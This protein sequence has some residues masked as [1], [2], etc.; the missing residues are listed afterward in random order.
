[1]FVDILIDYLSLVPSTP[2]AISIATMVE[3]AGKSLPWETADT[4]RVP[5]PATLLDFSETLAG[6]LRTP[7]K[8]A[9][10]TL[11]WEWLLIEDAVNRA[12][13]ILHQEQRGYLAAPALEAI[14]ANPWY[15]TTIV[16]LEVAAAYACSVPRDVKASQSL[17]IAAQRAIP[18][19]SARVVNWYRSMQDRAKAWTGQ[20]AGLPVHPS[21]RYQSLEQSLRLPVCPP[22]APHRDAIVLTEALA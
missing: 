14:R 3:R 11:P 9:W 15:G 1:M 17:I 18:S 4:W 8:G 20:H 13:M 6:A 7:G 5:T 21:R 12:F 16:S 22:R 19:P 10:P 2:R